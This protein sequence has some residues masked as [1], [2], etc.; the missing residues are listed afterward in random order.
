[1]AR[2]R[3]LKPG[4]FSNEMLCEI[5]MAGRLL[6]A[7]LWTLADRKGRLPD[8][9]KVIKGQL[10]PYE[11]VPVDKLLGELAQRGFILRYQVDGER[12]IQVVKF[13]THQHV[14]KN[15]TDS[16]IPTP[17]GWDD[18]D[19][20]VRNAPSIGDTSTDIVETAPAEASSTPTPNSK[21][22]ARTEAISRRERLK[23]TYALAEGEWQALFAKHPGVNVG[24]RYWEFLDWI[25]ESEELRRPRKGTFV[26]F[27]G[28]LGVPKRASN[29]PR[30]I[31]EEQAAYGV[32]R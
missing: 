27:D 22:E 9:P 7:G 30:G 31:R 12:Y 5:P 25:G 29:I 28:F 17:N 6:F 26:A 2:A 3:L 19:T 18:S 11:N 32:V 13:E 14:H 8:R 21:A 1:M 10:F 24:A 23:A 20:L 16:I 4:F 15:E